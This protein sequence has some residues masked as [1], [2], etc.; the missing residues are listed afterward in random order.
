MWSAADDD[1]SGGN[2]D[3]SVTVEMNI[4]HG[5]GLSGYDGGCNEVCYVRVCVCVCVC[6]RVC[7]CV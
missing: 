5:G 2:K 6:V 7:V 3:A 4:D 1:G